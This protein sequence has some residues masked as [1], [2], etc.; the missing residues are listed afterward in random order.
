MRGNSQRGVGRRS[1]LK[2]TAG[3]GAGA[4][5]AVAII[6]YDGQKELSMPVRFGYLSCSLVALYVPAFTP[7]VGSMTTTGAQLLAVAAGVAALVVAQQ[8]GV[9]ASAEPTSND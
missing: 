3:L 6:G 4:A 8:R 2:T 9:P 5:L 7:F 1:F